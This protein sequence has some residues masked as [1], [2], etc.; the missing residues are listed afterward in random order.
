MTTTKTEDAK[1]LMPQ[2]AVEAQELLNN[3]GVFS[4]NELDFL[5]NISEQRY[6]PTPKQRKWMDDIG[7]RDDEW[8]ANRFVMPMQTRKAMPL[9]Q[10]RKA[11]ARALADPNSNV[12][13]IATR[14][15][16]LN[17]PILGT[18]PAGQCPPK[19]E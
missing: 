16:L 9:A 12:V 8:Y 14:H 10:V 3:P 7:R 4:A 6:P 13:D 17:K 11:R 18:L 2:W 1:H 19:A 5:E 15:R